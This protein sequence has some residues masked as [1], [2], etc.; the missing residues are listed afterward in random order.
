MGAITGQR[1]HRCENNG[2]R[3]TDLGVVRSDEQ[4]FNTFVQRLDLWAGCGAEQGSNRAPNPP[5][6]FGEDAPLIGHHPQQLP[7]LWQSVSTA[8]RQ[9]IGCFAP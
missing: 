4:R 5:G 8:C 2:R 6:P 9:Q 3:V 7:T 1:V